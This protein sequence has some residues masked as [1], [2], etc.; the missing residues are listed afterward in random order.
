MRT[1]VVTALLLTASVRAPGSP[2]A[3]SIDLNLD[4]STARIGGT[5]LLPRENRPAPCVVIVGGTLSHL[6]D[7]GMERPG[8]PERAALKRFAETLARA[9]YGS[10][11]Y[12][13]V[14]R[15]ASRPKAGWK[16]LYQGDARVLAD[17]Y[18]HLRSR[19]E[20][21]KIIAA[22][23]S[24]GAYIASLA[25]REG[26]HADAYLFLGAFCGKAEEIFEYNHGRLAQSAAASSADAA[27]ARQNNLERYIAYGRRWREMF[28]AA[29]ARR[30]TWELVDGSFHETVPLA[31]HRGA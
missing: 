11:R 27:W 28:A 4:L 30:A 2:N 9:G 3:E 17:L 20:C 15:G 16:D 24:A 6:R 29:R 19:P 31:A 7:G 5:L 21:G 12:D 25:A 22:G 23:E 10:F 8:V 18:S 1:A 14:G 26:A 13:Q